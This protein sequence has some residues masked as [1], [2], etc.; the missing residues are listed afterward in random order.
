MSL[1]P[2]IITVRRKRRAGAD[3][4]PVNFLRVEE[5]KRQRSGTWLYRRKQPE[6]QHIPEQTAPGIS[7]GKPIIHSSRP[8]DEKVPL[9]AL[10]HAPQPAP[11][12]PAA[13]GT[14]NDAALPGS[15]TASPRRFH[16]S[17]FDTPDRTPGRGPKRSRFASAIF[18]ER[19]GQRKKT[20]ETD[21]ESAAALQEETA[22]VEMGD[23][24]VLVQKRPGARARVP[25][26]TASPAPKLPASL[27]Q[28]QYDTST[29]ALS[30]E[31]NSWALEQ[32]AHNLANQED[33]RTRRPG[34]HTPTKY[35]PKAP[36]KRFADRHPEIVS[37]SR[38]AD[39]DVDGSQDNSETEDEDYV[40]ET[41]VRVPA[42]TLNAPVPPDQLGVLVFGQESDVEYF[43]GLEDDSEDEF[44]EDE[45]DSN[46]ENHYTNEYPE[47]E[48]ESDDEY[49]R[50]DYRYRT[51]NA[52]DEE[53]FDDADADEV[54]KSDDESGL[55]G[56]KLWR[57]QSEIRSR[58]GLPKLK[59]RV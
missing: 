56:T 1:P 55:P 7:P 40:M 5:T 23:A 49:G 43:Y 4:G 35:R 51:G 11:T 29:E 18:V 33:E 24:P 27:A 36:A 53:E 8:G 44:F 19:S 59:D 20:A 37:P 2:E 57:Q 47:D 22:D 17:R 10:R 3:D 39:M 31:M 14:P 16:L 46:D 15:G 38:D 41:Y 42:H 50:D 25:P 45:D 28:R 30:R 13:H 34:V 58:L 26:K 52:S 48:V 32:I 12:A 21:E 9:S 54:V 6:T